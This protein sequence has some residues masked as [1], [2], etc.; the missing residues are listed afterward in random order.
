MVFF[1]GQPGKT[2]RD[3]FLEWMLERTR[4]VWKGYKHSPTDSGRCWVALV[5]LAILCWSSLGFADAGLELMMLGAIGMPYHSLLVIICC[6][7][8]EG[9]ILK[10]FWWCSGKPCNFFWI[11]LPLLVHKRYLQIDWAATTD[12]CELNN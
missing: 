1:W 9:N 3:I 5:H 7:F 6:D 11:S 8:I 12:S 2:A 4:D 10:N